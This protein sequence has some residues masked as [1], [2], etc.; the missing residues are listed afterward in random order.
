VKRPLASPPH[1]IAAESAH[2]DAFE[3]DE[4][5]RQHNKLLAIEEDLKTCQ[6]RVIA[7]Q[8][9]YTTGEGGRALLE[10]FA[11]LRRH[12]RLSNPRLLKRLAV[13]V[14]PH[15]LG[16]PA[17]ARTQVLRA[18]QRV[19]VRL[20]AVPSMS[21]SKDLATL[22]EA[23]QMAGP[24]MAPQESRTRILYARLTPAVA[25]LFDQQVHMQRK[26]LA[27]KGAPP[28]MRSRDQIFSA[29]GKAADVSRDVVRKA[30]LLEIGKPGR[31]HWAALDREASANNSLVR[32]RL[33]SAKAAAAGTKIAASKPSRK[34]DA[35]DAGK[36]A[37]SR[38]FKK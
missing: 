1:S 25:R 5:L 2:A 24:E 4:W 17:G 27:D 20:L 28:F 31:E 29:V 7:F 37:N 15:L 35:I 18:M 38:L 6:T 10:A 9:L 26:F 33:R 36:K 16:I 11:A 14:A 30:W 13:Q 22:R 12:D 23:L 34:A 19:T 3:D 8:R 21:Q 32:T